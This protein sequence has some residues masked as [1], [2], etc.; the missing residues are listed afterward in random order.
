MAAHKFDGIERGWHTYPEAQLATTLEA[1]EAIVAHYGLVDILGHDDIAPERKQDPGPAFP[2]EHFRSSLIGRADDDFELFETTTA[3][4][5]RGG[6]GVQFA[7]LTAEALVKGTR[8][9]V[10][11]RDGSWCFAEVL[12]ADDEPNLTGWVHGNFIAPVAYA[13]S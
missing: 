7:K 6:P 3:L 13:T 8:L 12:D 10:E 2:I 9:E 11:L 1:A 5:I 4:N